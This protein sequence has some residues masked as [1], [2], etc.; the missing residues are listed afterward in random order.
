MEKH[1]FIDESG[2]PQFYANRGRPLWNEPD[3]VPIISLGMVTTDDRKRL[4]KAVADFQ[5]HILNDPLLN[6]IYSV[7]QDGWHF[8]ARCDHSD[9]NLKMVE[10]L[11][12]LEGFSFSAVIGRKIPDIFINK[13]NGSATE[14]YFDLIHKLL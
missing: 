4:R 3:F 7:S 14:F 2:S 11:R 5:A 1:I 12:Q 6:S 10:F 8:H 13:H 9:I